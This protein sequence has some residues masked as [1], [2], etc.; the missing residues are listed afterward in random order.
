MATVTTTAVDILVEMLREERQKCQQLTE[1]LDST[2][3]LIREL[4]G[5][6]E[7][8]ERTTY[9]GWNTD[10]RRVVECDYVEMEDVT[11]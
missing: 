10:R 8:R 9:M 6:L 1:E 5:R 4:I 7:A 11:P 2:K 3:E